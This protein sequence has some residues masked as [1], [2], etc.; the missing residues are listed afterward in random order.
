MKAGLL[1]IFA[2]VVTPAHFAGSLIKS[3]ESAGTRTDEYEV[4]RDRWD[5]EDSTTV[6]YCQRSCG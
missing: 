4:T 6:S 3:V 5:R 1:S 2:N